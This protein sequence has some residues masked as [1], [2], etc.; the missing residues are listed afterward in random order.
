M[1]EHCDAV[2]IEEEMLPPEGVIGVHLSDQDSLQ[3]DFN[4]DKLSDDEVKEFASH[5]EPQKFEKCLFRLHGRACEA[6]AL[7]L[8]KKV[9]RLPGVRRASA[10]FLG[11]TMSISFD[12]GQTNDKK[13]LDEV[14][15]QGAPVASWDESVSTSDKVELVFTVVTLLSM[16][17]AY[18]VPTLR[19]PALPLSPCLPPSPLHLP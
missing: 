1:K 13:L 11:G 6:C 8:E 9:E 3:I 14:Q 17:V 16:I 4:P 5:L 7:K 18:L 10:T 2:E 15:K 19:F 12:G